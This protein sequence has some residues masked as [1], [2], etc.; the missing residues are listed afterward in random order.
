MSAREGGGIVGRAPAALFAL[1]A[2]ALRSFMH[3]LG[4]V[5]D[6]PFFF[7]CSEVSANGPAALPRCARG[8][9]VG[10]FGLLE[11][12]GHM[13]A[14][15]D[16]ANGKDGAKCEDAGGNARDEARS[17]ACCCAYRPSVEDDCGKSR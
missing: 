8:V 11:A 10:D 14:I 9:A 3:V 12:D 13:K 7:W 2:Q 4:V 15:E 17:L 16:D 6:H 1:R 5:F